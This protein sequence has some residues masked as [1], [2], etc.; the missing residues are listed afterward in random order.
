MRSPSPWRLA[1]VVLALLVVLPACD[2]GTDEPTPAQDQIVGGVNFT[3]LFAPATA[4]E[5]AAVRTE[6]DN[7][8]LSVRNVTGVQVSA[9]PATLPDGAKLYVVSHLITTGPGAGADARHYGFVRV[10]AGAENLPVVVVHHGGDRGVYAAT[11]TSDPNADVLAVAALYPTLAS[12]TVQVFP[13]YRSEPLGTQPFDAVLGGPYTSGGTPSP[14][15]YDV[16]DAIMLLSAV[17]QRGEFASATN[18]GLVGALGFSRG[19]NTALLHNIRDQ[20]IRATTQYY[21]PTDFFS[22]PIQGLATGVLGGSP[23][24]LSFPGAPFLLANVLQPLQGPGQTYNAD[25]D[26][27]RARLEVVRRSTSAF[28]S[29][30]RSIQVHHHTADPVVPYPVS[31]SFDAAATTARPSRVYE[32]YSYSDPLPAGATYSQ[33][34]PRAMPASIGRTEQF[35]GQYIGARMARP[36]ASQP[37]LAD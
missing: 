1:A 12:T 30:M 24:F 13:S 16:D 35:L 7:R 33:H 27:A 11:P 4:P 37:V 22:T 28:T 25:A 18:D 31:V 26:Y 3:R 9:T 17:L 8:A 20:R 2:S 32:F 15:D 5:I 14:W 29:D 10:P 34:N 19:A 21:G 23:Q 36:V 6:W